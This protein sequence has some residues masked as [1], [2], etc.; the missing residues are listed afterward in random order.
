MFLGLSSGSDTVPEVSTLRWLVETALLV[1]LAFALAQGIKTY[2]VQ[3]FVIPSGSMIPT[4]Q[5]GDRVFAEKITY[6]F[7]RGPSAGDVVVFDNPQYNPAD[8]SMAPPILIKR[9]IAVAGQTVDLK[10]GRVLV[11]GK[12]LDE[13]YTHGKPSD[14]LDPAIVYPLELAPGMMWVM[15]DN[16][17]NSGDSRAIGPVAVKA[18]IGRAVWKY[19]PLTAFGALR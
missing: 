5:E 10:D 17:T 12:V 2:L 3:A 15:G 11:D 14:P 19:W 4:I 18:A 16:R 6:R 7:V 1:L 13:P 8:P 9:V